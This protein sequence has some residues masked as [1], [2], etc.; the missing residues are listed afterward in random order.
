[1]V[2]ESVTGSFT[3]LTQYGLAG[4]MLAITLAAIFLMWDEY[5]TQDVK[6]REEIIQYSGEDRASAIE[7]RTKLLD[8]FVELSNV[9]NEI[10]RKTVDY[11]FDQL[12]KID[13]EHRVTLAA[14]IQKQHELIKT[15]TDCLEK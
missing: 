3:K 8:R 4:T 2:D 5:H 15:M 6:L 9:R 13:T 12:V 10:N 14:L 1:M 7:D 11:M